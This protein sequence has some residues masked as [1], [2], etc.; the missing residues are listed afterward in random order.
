M[1]TLAF[2]DADEEE[3]VR[4]LTWQREVG[5][6]EGE[7]PLRCERVTAAQ[8]RGLEPALDGPVR[9]GIWW[10]QTAQLDNTRLVEAYRQ[11]ILSQGG[12]IRTDTPVSR[13]LVEQDQVVGVETSSEP[14]RADWVVN[15]T[16][17]W[18]GFD[19][20]LSLTF[21]TVPVKGQILQFRTEA[22]LLQRIVK[23]PRAYLVQR[24]PD[25]LIAGTTVEYVGYDK[26]VTEAGKR[27]IQE[28][29]QEMTSRLAAT[30][31]GKAWAGLRPGTPD[32]LPILGETPFK[33]L[34]VATGHF[35]NGIL[36]APLTGRLIADLICTGTCSMD[37]SPFSV[38]RFLAGER[39]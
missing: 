22:P 36:L 31:W 3:L 23:S 35:R 19:R 14:I 7:S 6:R 1:F 9:W 33:R 5:L 34:L 25:Q 8:I 38:T 12:V 15:C 32:R 39:V 13:F 21:P 28:G 30:P 11:L 26:S 16:G 4:H 37:L 17:S 27:W 2:S 18:A 29:T 24:S 10:P 20:S